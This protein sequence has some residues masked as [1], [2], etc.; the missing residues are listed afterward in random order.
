MFTDS[1]FNLNKQWLIDFCTLFAEQTTLPMSCNIRANIM[2][3]DIAKALSNA[4]CDPVRFAIETGNEKLRNSILQ[5]NVTDEQIYYTAGLFKKY[6]LPFLA[7]GMMCLPTETLEMAWQTIHMNQK[8]NPNV[9]DI[10]VFM[11]YPNM[12]ITKYAIK[13]GL[14]DK[15]S[16]KKMT[17]GSHKMFRPVL[18]QKDIGKISNL[19]K[20]SPLLIRFPKLEGIVKK[21]I[22]LPENIVFD[23]IYGLSIVIEFMGWSKVSRKRAIMEI[24]KNFRELT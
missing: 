11:P 5:K 3:E 22:N 23:G 9:V 1:T 16:F 21:L 19:H 7:F 8:I 15:D 2:D 14:L 24:A 6:K 17:E 10:G 13:E 18:K 4:R 12:N 20:F